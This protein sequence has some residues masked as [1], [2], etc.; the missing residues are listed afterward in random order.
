MTFGAEVR[1]A[2]S[3]ETGRPRDFASSASGA[4]AWTACGRAR[5]GERNVATR[6]PGD[7]GDGD[8]PG[9]L[10]L[11]AQAAHTSM[12]QAGDGAVALTNP[13]RTPSMPRSG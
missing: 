9:K 7:R 3:G 11:S 6:F 4:G 10:T 12:Q 5:R 8:E 1:N 2:M 13:K